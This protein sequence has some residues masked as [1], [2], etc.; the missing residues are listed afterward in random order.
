MP[1][2]SLFTFKPNFSSLAFNSALRN[3]ET[4][5]VAIDGISNV[6]GTKQFSENFILVSLRNATTRISHFAR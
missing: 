5:S 4:E 1:C 2:L 3:V 6:A